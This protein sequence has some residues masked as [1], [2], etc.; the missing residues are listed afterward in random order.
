MTI[1]DKYNMCINTK[2]VNKPMYK[3]F[4]FIILLFAMTIFSSKIS[5]A[6]NAAF[7]SAAVDARYGDKDL[8]K[9]YPNPLVS[10]ATIKVSDDID[11]ERTKVSIVFY[12]MVGSEVY[13]ISQMKDYEEKISRDVFK[14]AG[15]YFYQ[16]KADDKVITTGRITVK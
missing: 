14:N 12:N 16:L 4:T 2:I 5:I 15:M 6:K 13:R 11:L 1:F 10:D 3:T 7:E 8:I 9:F